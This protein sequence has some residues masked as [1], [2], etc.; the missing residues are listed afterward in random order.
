MGLR[1]RLQLMRLLVIKKKSMSNSLLTGL[2]LLSIVCGSCQPSCCQME[3]S[4]CFVPPPY[5]IEKL[6]A[7]FCPL[8]TVERSQDWGKELYLGRTFAKE[9]DLYRALT[10]FKRALIL[11]PRTHERRYEIEY[12]IF[13]TYYV[14]NKYQEAIEAF[15]GSKLIEIPETFPIFRDLLI[16]LYDCY[17]KEDLPERACRILNAIES[18]DAEAANNLKLQT[19]VSEA[20]FPQIVDHAS[21]SPANETISEFLTTYFTQSKSVKKAQVLNAVLPGAGYWYVGQKKSAITSFVINSLFIA[22]AYQLFNRGYIAG[23]IIVTSLETGWYF[24]GINGA[25]LEAKQYNETLYNRV[26]SSALARERL[27]PI[28]MIEKGF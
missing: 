14:A 8:T 25:G 3:P 22:A 23:G 10:C 27:F 7:P 26:G 19:A 1:L 2:L 6:P 21:C 28:L 20:D 24:G 9:M 15:E 13:F 4:I 5:T 12:E 17:I 16:A 18:L 11:I